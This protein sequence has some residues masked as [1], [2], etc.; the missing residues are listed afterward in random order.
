MRIT[1]DIYEVFSEQVR[2]APDHA[3]VIEENRTWTYAQLD[4]L[5]RAIAEKL[6]EYPG[7]VGVAMDHGALMLASMFGIL[8][9]G[10]AFVPVEPDIPVQRVRTMFDLADVKIVLAA[11]Q[12]EEL[13][14]GRE[15]I[16]PA[17]DWIP[18]GEERTAAQAGPSAPAYVLFTSGTTGAPKGII[19]TNGNVLHYVQAFQHEFRVGPNDIMAQQSACTFDIFVE[20]V[21][22]ALLNGAPVAVVPEHARDNVEHFS[23]FI[24]EHGVT[25]VSGFPYLL[26]EL[27]RLDRIPESI[28]LLISGGDVLRLGYVDRLFDQAQIY[29]TYGPSETTVCATYYKC[30]P[31][32]ALTNGTF[33]IGYPVVGSNVVIV[34]PAG[35]KQQRGNP[36]ELLVTGDG[37]TL[38][39]TPGAESDAFGELDGVPSYRTGDMGYEMDDGAIVFTRR[40]DTQVMIRGRRVEPGE[41]ENV[42][43]GIDGV[44]TAYVLSAMDDS[45]LTYLTAYV[46]PENPDITMRR[47]RK[48]LEAYLPQ[49]M[50]PEF[51]VKMTEIPLTENGKPNLKAFP[52]VMKEGS[53]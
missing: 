42:L 31:D 22:C 29:N 2:R 15:V 49:Y 50:I 16:V 11:H 6:P 5:A 4:T 14:K 25:I 20:E 3:A 37:V 47:I 30:T 19:A 41:V 9:A 28:R 45:G 52:I 1:K 26:L 43:C 51:I 13:A 21:F 18:E 27:N 7:N 24:E 48:E 35:K 12:Y 23:R 44:A 10:G 8:R 40:K 53:L 39:Y 34:D 32:N 36:G 46:V 33:P 38:G 17:K